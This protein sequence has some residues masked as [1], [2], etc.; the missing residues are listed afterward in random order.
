MKKKPV[1]LLSFLIAAAAV[2][3]IISIV[4]EYGLNRYA[5][6]LMP[7][8]FCI[9]AAAL[10]IASAVIAFFVPRRDI[11]FTE[12]VL[13][14]VLLFETAIGGF[15]YYTAPGMVFAAVSIA[16][17]LAV[18]LRLF[19]DPTGKIVISAAAFVPFALFLIAVLLRYDSFDDEL[20]RTIPSPNGERY[21]ELIDEHG[22]FLGGD[23]YVSLCEKKDTFAGIFRTRLKE[24]PIHWA[25]DRFLLMDEEG[26]IAYPEIVWKDDTAVIINGTEYPI[27]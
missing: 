8:P 13:S 11:T 15:F 23:V 19:A 5:E 16:A 27:E 26:K 20:V 10:F 22:N 24:Q 1:V 14:A 21:V 7:L 12:G 25:E 18:F 9:P 3:P 17:A 2:W 6:A 4:F